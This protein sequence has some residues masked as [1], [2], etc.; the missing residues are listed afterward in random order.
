MEVMSSSTMTLTPP[1]SNYSTP[2]RHTTNGVS[3]PKPAPSS[4]YLDYTSSPSTNNLST[5]NEMNG[6]KLCPMRT[7]RSAKE[8]VDDEQIERGINELFLTTDNKIVASRAK[9][10]DYL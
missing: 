1:S 5:P 8:V 9:T 4:K 3:T 6:T 10:S 7:A 2:S